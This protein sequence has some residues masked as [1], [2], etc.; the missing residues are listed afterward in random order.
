MHWLIEAFRRC[1]S[2]SR[3]QPVK[4]VTTCLTCQH[5]LVCCSVLRE[6]H[7]C[8]WKT[9]LLKPSL[10]HLYAGKALLF[11]NSI[12]RW[13]FWGRNMLMWD[14]TEPFVPQLSVQSDP[15]TVPQLQQLG[16]LSLSS[17]PGNAKFTISS[18]RSL[19]AQ[20]NCSGWLLASTSMNLQREKL[21]H[22]D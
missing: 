15:F 17:R 8:C 18:T 9:G 20:S 19:M 22:L 1:E 21:D 2:T 7:C 12:L 10:D 16:Y 4:A 3:V 14:T 6:V 11:V 13:L 5:L